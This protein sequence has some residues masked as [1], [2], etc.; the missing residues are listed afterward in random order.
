MT[1]V[2]HITHIKN[3]ESILKQGGLCCDSI[4]GE[5]N[6]G[7][8]EIAYTDL[9]GRRASRVVPI[10]PGGTLSDYVPFYFAP[11]SP[12]LYVI[13]KGGVPGYSAGQAQ[14][15]H[16]VAS[17]EQIEQSNLKF[18]FTD[19]HAYMAF[20]QFF[21]NLVNLNQLDWNIMREKYWNDTAEDGDRMRRRNAEFLVH[22]FLPWSL[23][24]EIG[25]MNDRIARDLTTILEP[26]AYR[27][28]VTV[29]PHWYY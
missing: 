14:V 27:P 24:T 2:F 23:I 12:M 15:L 26:T 1:A 6:L 3:I 7:P 19:G 21:N 28:K 16:L 11:R 29:C 5:R 18:V 13:S 22:R 4:V 17:A 9:K 20:S 8:V 10:A 25:V